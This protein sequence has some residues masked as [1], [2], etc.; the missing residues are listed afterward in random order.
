MRRPLARTA[1]PGLARLQADN[2]NR[3]L[4]AKMA[5][6]RAKWRD[7]DADREGMAQLCPTLYS[8]AASVVAQQCLAEKEPMVRARL[9]SLFAR[10]CAALA[11][12]VSVACAP[13][14]APLGV[15]SDTP[16]LAPAH[17][18][19]RDG[20][21]LPLRAWGPAQPKAVVVALHGMSDYSNA[22]AIPGG[23]WAAHGITTLAYDQRGFGQSDHPGLWP[24]GDVLRG[25]FADA[26][27]AARVRYP[28]VPIYALGESMGGAVV[29]SALASGAVPNVDGVILVAPAVWSRG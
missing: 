14:L 13:T 19:T 15:A 27:A 25:D 2:F 18:L 1:L 26:V 9:A 6:G 3:R 16:T 22:F 11:V 12:L 10:A 4:R 17:F 8:P 21:K 29:L 28:G 5:S 24:G 7:L 20:T 23:W